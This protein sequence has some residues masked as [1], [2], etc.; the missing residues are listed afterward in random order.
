MTLDHITRHLRHC[1]YAKVR[2]YNL[3]I[4]YA[5][6]IHVMLLLFL[7]CSNATCFWSLLFRGLQIELLL[8]KQEN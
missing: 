8:D 4:S 5:P 6:H 1:F 2:V 3:S 7:P